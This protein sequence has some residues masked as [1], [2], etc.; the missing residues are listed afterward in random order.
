MKKRVIASLLAVTLVC[1]MTACGEKDVT[2]TVTEKAEAEV[3]EEIAEAAEEA[4]EEVAEEVAEEV[5][6]EVA[7]EPVEE[8]AEG[9]DNISIGVNEGNTYE[10]AFF[11]VGCTLDSDWTLESQEQILARNKLAADMVDEKFAE[12][13]ESGAVIT[14]MVATNSNGVDTVNVG[15]EKLVGGAMLIDEDKYIELSDPQVTEMLGSMGLENVTSTQLDVSLA[16][17]NHAGLLIEAEYS[18][19]KVYEE[20]V[21]IKNGSYILCVT[22]CTWQEN[23][24]DDILSTFYALQ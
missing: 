2:G 17:E 13:F 18:G 16:G 24:V 19:I 12:V 23:K 3:T 22:A 6:E 7:E 15:I 21:C 20:L 1:M 5:E 11:G 10:N 9:D 14:D 4:V 8:A